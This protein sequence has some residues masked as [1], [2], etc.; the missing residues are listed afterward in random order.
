MLKDLKTILDFETEIMSRDIENI[1]FLVR[2]KVIPRKNA[3]FCNCFHGN[4]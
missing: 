2:I 4:G 3:F 1:I